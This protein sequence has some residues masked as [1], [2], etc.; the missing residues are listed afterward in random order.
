MITM[1]LKS[2]AA[3]PIRRVQAIA[4]TGLPDAMKIIAQ[5]TEV[6]P[7]CEPTEMSRP[8]SSMTT[9]WTTARIPTIVIVVPIVAMFLA[10]KKLLFCVPMKGD[11]ENQGNQQTDVLHP[12][13][14]QYSPQHART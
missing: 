12:N 13:Y 3:A 10:K 5:A 9:V 6:K 11:Q 1:P 2:P 7:A 4:S 8:P 14:V